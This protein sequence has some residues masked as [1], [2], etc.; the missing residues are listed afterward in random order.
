MESIIPHAEHRAR[1][2]REVGEKLAAVMDSQSALPIQ[3][4]QI[5]LKKEELRL[6]LWHRAGGGGKE[7]AGRRTE[8]VDILFRE[9]F[10]FATRME[11]GEKEIMGFMV[12]AFGGYGRRE[13]NPFSDVD[14]TFFHR[15]AR[16]T[17]DMEKVISACLKALWDLGFKVGH[18]TRSIKGAI[19]QANK[20]MMAKTAMLES[21][22]LAG[23]KK[24]K[25]A[26][27][28]VTTDMPS[29]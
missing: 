15:G 23:D 26:R 1:I 10:R 22:W 28:S 4:L 7:I 24:P 17:E 14:I 20:D 25:S 27:T 29:S 3:K 12:S 6:K 11:T 8:L 9:I 13:M 19:E 18:A 2:Q 5:F 16:P 21:R